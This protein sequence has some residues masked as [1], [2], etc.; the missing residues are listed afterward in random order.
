MKKKLLEKKHEDYV[1]TPPTKKA[2]KEAIAA[3]LQ[4]ACEMGNEV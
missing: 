3:K 4:K 1:G 2:K